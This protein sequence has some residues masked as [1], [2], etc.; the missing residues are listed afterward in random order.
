MCVPRSGAFILERDWGFTWHPRRPRR[1][2]P[3]ARALFLMC[4]GMDDDAR[5]ERESDVVVTGVSIVVC[6]VCMVLCV[7]GGSLKCG[8]GSIEPRRKSEGRR[9][10]GHIHRH[11]TPSFPPLTH[12]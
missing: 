11:K 5:E 10:R 2:P 9:E 8:D 3:A 7:W 12:A 4:L 1:A 6:G